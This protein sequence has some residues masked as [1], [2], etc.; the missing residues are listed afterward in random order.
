MKHVE[1]I[2]QRVYFLAIPLVN[3]LFVVR[4]QFVWPIIMLL[5]A[6][7]LQDHMPE[8]QMIYQLDANLFH[9]S[10]I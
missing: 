5:N 10:I 2:Q 1:V 3:L 9:V 8:I 4:M 6:N 7:A